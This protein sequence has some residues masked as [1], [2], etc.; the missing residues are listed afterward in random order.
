MREG[1]GSCRDKDRREEELGFVVL[2]LMS[3][4]PINRGR[5]SKKSTSENED[6]SKG[7]TSVN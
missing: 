3:C 7:T 4:V 2:G 5:P 1:S 6:L